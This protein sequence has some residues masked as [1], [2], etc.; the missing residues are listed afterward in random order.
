VLQFHLGG[1]GLPEFEAAFTRAIMHTT[2]T[3]IGVRCLSGCDL[4]Q[5]KRKAARPQD[6]ADIRFLEKKAE[7]GLLG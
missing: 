6:Q 4:L 1:P 2:E 5:S 3:G 7:M